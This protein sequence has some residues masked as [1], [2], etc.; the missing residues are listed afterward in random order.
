MWFVSS[1]PSA[2]FVYSCPSAEMIWL[3]VI[4]MW[5]VSSSPSAW[6]VSSF[7]SAPICSVG[8]DNSLDLSAC[9]LNRVSPIIY[10]SLF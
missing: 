1:F 4:L 2:W 9:F 7:P 8:S 3:H 10:F 5:F 6:F